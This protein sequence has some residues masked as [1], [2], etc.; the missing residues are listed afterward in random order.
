V[1]TARLGCAVLDGVCSVCVWGGCCR[2]RS[3]EAVEDI[4]GG[5]FDADGGAVQLASGDRGQLAELVSIFDAGQGPE[6][7]IRTHFYFSPLSRLAGPTLLL[8]DGIGR[9][10]VVGLV[11]AA[12][13]DGP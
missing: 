10:E 13:L 4:V 1:Q 5:V 3:A 2:V 8:W 7:E 6:D 11:A 12:K 9:D